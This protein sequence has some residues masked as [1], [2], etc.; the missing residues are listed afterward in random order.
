LNLNLTK[1]ANQGDAEFMCGFC[2]FI[3]F[4]PRERNKEAMNRELP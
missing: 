4:D 2:G 1:T 3:D